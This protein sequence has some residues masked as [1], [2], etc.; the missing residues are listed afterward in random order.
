MFKTLSEGLVWALR[1]LLDGRDLVDIRPQASQERITTA[2]QLI[3]YRSYIRSWR[4]KFVL[5]RER[6]GHWTS[7]VNCEEHLAPRRGQGRVRRQCEK[8]MLAIGVAYAA[9]RSYHFSTPPSVWR[10]IRSPLA[11]D[12]TDSVSLSVSACSG[13]RYS[14]PRC[15]R[16]AW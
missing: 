12:W 4:R 14:R 15:E 3:E 6:R 16:L 9:F 1:W 13:V 5:D 10:R 8:R 2:Q 7:S 11:S